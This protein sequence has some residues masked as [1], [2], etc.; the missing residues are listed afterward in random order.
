MLKHCTKRPAQLKTINPF[1]DIYDF[2]HITSI[3]IFLKHGEKKYTDLH[4]VALL[5]DT[6]GVIIII[7]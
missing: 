6:P 5:F 3:V 7:Y 4:F 2:S 1:F